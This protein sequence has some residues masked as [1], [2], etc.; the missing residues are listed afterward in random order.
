MVSF[1]DALWPE[2]QAGRLK[3]SDVEADIVHPNDRGHAYAAQ[4]VTR[5]LERA[6]IRCRAPSGCRNQSPWA[7]RCLRTDSSI[8]RWRK[9]TRSTAHEQRVAFDATNHCW[10]SDEPGSVIEFEIAGRAV[11]TMHRVF[12]GPMGRA[13]VTVDGGRRKNS[14]A[15]STRP[16]AGIGRRGN[17]PVTCGRAT[18]ACVLN[19]WRRRCGQHRP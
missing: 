5:L 10:K 9:P 3:W 14:R 4:F 13:R 17:L 16:G 18:I 1:R 8:R 19:C 15:G 2:I 7:R 11:L 6:C 12:R